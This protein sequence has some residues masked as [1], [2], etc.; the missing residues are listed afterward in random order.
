MTSNEFPVLRLCK[1]LT[2]IM[3]QFKQYDIFE[4][5]MDL[6]PEITMGMTGV[7]LEVLSN[8]IYEVEFVEEDGTNLKFEGQSTFTVDLSY[9]K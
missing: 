7:I 8:N 3:K 1:T 6:N 9:F 4:L 2:A 5:S